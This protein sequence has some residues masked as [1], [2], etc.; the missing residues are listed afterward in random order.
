M[1]YTLWFDIVD[2]EAAAVALCS[3]L[4]QQA[5]PYMRKRHPAHATPW[6]EP[7]MPGAWIVWSYC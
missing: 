2:S 1:K 7:T 4:N 3:R 5:T 6:N